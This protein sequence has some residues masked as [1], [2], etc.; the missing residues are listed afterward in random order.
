MGMPASRLCTARGSPCVRG[1]HGS[2]NQRR[3]E[4][5]TTLVPATTR[6]DNLGRSLVRQKDSPKRSKEA[7]YLAYSQ[8]F[9]CSAASALRNNRIW[10]QPRQT[11]SLYPICL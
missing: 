8:Y 3:I 2:A 6:V 11:L 10:Q 5:S 7:T 4:K 9:S 1:D